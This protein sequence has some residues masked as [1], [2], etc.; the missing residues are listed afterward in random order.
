MA[1]LGPGCK[2]K[3]RAPH[4]QIVAGR[5]RR[6]GAG[7]D[8]QPGPVCLNLVCAPRET[9]GRAGSGCKNNRPVALDG[10]ARA[11]R[12][13]DRLFVYHLPH[14]L[15]RSTAHTRQ[16]ALFDFSIF[17]AAWHECAQDTLAES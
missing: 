8:T 15:W 9:F 3:H 2:V 7:W 14:L 10:A 12:G 1:A 4:E 11:T 16:S 13:I 6:A 5:S 17:G